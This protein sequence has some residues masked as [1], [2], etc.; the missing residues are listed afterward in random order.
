MIFRNFVLQ[1]FPFLED[2]FDALTDYELFCKMVEYMKKS[3]DKIGEYQDELNEFRTELDTYKEYFDNLDVQEEVN[4][5]LDEMAESGELADII[6]QYLGLAGILAFNTVNDLKNAENIA[7]GS[8]VK[9]IGYYSVN[10]GGG[11]YY[12]IREITNQDVIDEAS[13]IAVSDV[14]LVAEIICDEVNLS[15]FG[16]YGDGTHDD[17][18][19]F[20]NAVSYAKTNNLKVTSSKNKT[21]LISDTIDIS[22]LLFDL[23]DATIKA[24]SA[25]DMLEIDEEDSY[26]NGHFQNFVIDCNDIATKGINII[27]SRRSKF[28]NINIINLSGIGI[29]F[30]AGYEN[31]FDLINIQSVELTNTSNIGFKIE[32]GDSNFNNITMANICNPFYLKRCYSN[33]FDKIHTWIGQSDLIEY[34][35]MF[36]I[37]I[38]YPETLLIN[39]I[40][41]DTMRY[42]IKYEVGSSYIDNSNI[43]N[44]IIDYNKGIYTKDLDDSILLYC[45]ND[46]QT[47][48]I[49]ISSGYINGLYYSDHADSDAKTQLTNRTAFYGNI[50][51]TYF[52]AIGYNNNRSLTDVNTNITL[53]VNDII[54][55]GNTIY[56]SIV[57]S[58]NSSSLSG[59]IQLGKIPNEIAPKRAI[60]STCIVSDARWAMTNPTLSY[61]YIP[62]VDSNESIQLTI[63]SGDSTKYIFITLC[64]NI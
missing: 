5:K 10:D 43:S 19:K 56:V 32:S 42:F 34:S 31:M 24:S 39:E 63:P 6:A 62:V 30:Q 20:Q 55:N 7:D 41:C 16:L 23:N 40:Y 21:Y 36:V 61:M 3:L 13:I 2:D 59:N 4:N 26:K 27:N 58:Y 53:T 1:N 22:N 45:N 9:T 15:C 18:L 35:T 54:K 46:D 33:Y 64:Y 50:D 57:G 25:I 51:N 44:L 29:H 47:K 8:I 37:D 12:K 28:N 11:S 60:T 49:H 17:T 14:D 52:S 38:P 48:H